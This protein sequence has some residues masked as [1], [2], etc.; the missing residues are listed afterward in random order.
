MEVGKSL[1]DFWGLKS[2]GVSK[3]GV[4]LVEVS[5]GNGGWKV[6]EFDASMNE[7][8]N[9]QRLG[10]G[11][12]KI[13]AGWSNSFRYRNFDLNLQFTGQFGFKIL[14]VQRCFYENNSIAYNKLKSA[15]NWYGANNY[16]LMRSPQLPQKK[17][18]D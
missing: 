17:S 11:L 5:D 15:S 2:V 13:Y 3:D 18:P 1:G 14:N 8:G 9:R 6:K 16:I 10:N 12:P 7:K 4:V